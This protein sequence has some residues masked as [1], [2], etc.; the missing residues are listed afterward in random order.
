M[1]SFVLSVIQVKLQCLNT[2]QA[3]SVEPLKW[4]V[5]IQLNIYIKKKHK[6]VFW[7]ISRAK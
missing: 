2:Q 6:T 7:N 3:H 5:I 4:L 1:L